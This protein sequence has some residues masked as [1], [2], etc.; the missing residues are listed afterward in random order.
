MAPAMVAAMVEMRMSRFRTW[1]ISWA[2]TPFN[3]VGVSRRMMPSV[4]ATAACSG[5]RPVAKALGES[6]GMM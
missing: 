4:A 2:S 3:S 1:P 5:L 6:S